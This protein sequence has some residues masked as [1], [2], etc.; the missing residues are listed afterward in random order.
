MLGVLAVT[1]TQAVTAMP[2]SLARVLAIAHHYGASI[3]DVRLTVQPSLTGRGVHYDISPPA[4][5][6][7]SARPLRVDCHRLRR[8]LWIVSG[9]RSGSSQFYGD[10]M[11][12]TTWS[13][14]YLDH[15]L[16]HGRVSVAAET[17]VGMD[18]SGG[19][20]GTAFGFAYSSDYYRCSGSHCHGVSS[21]SSS[22]SLRVGPER[23]AVQLSRRDRLPE[24]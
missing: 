9:R 2:D 17:R 24:R 1:R 5:S 19:A 21:Y 12:L 11:S 6:V 14:A 22:G 10:G 13:A 3:A 4:N 7:A 8:Q 20:D 18:V 23:P 15:A 16:A